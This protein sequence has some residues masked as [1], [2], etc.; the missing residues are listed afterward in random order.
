LPG[1]KEEFPYIKITLK[2]LY[3][4]QMKYAKKQFDEI[5]YSREYLNASDEIKSKINKQFKNAYKYLPYQTIE[6]GGF[7]L[8][9]VD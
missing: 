1:Q 3:E 5:I 8:L 2:D 9:D 4:F 6:R 7:L